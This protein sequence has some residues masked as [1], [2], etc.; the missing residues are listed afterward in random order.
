MLNRSTN[1]R[2]ELGVDD[3]EQPPGATVTEFDGEFD[4]DDLASLR[5]GSYRLIGYRILL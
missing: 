4:E 5:R 3:S 1:N 2:W